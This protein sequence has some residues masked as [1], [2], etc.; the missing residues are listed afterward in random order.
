M[1]T[2]ITASDFCLHS[3]HENLYCIAFGS[4]LDDKP[5]HESEIVQRSFH[6]GQHEPGTYRMIWYAKWF[7]VGTRWFVAVLALDNYTTI[8]RLFVQELQNCSTTPAQS[9][10]V[11]LVKSLRKSG[12]CM[13]SCTL[14]RSTIQVRSNLPAIASNGFQR[15]PNWP[16]A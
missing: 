9:E 5:Q 6:A 11:I 1:S 7:G 4:T 13:N 14:P 3:I 16:C 12:K 8:L 15:G 10:V 2:V